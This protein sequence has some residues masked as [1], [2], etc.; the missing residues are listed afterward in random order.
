MIVPRVLQITTLLLLVSIV[1]ACSDGTLIR[2]GVE[3][4][5]DATGTTGPD[6][7]VQT[8]DAAEGGDSG[9][10]LEPTDTGVHDSPPLPELPDDLAG[11][12]IVHEFALP[13]GAKRGVSNWR[14]W[15]RDSLGVAPVFTVPLMNCETLVCYTAEDGGAQL[16]RLDASD[17]LVETTELGSDLECRGLAAATD[18]RF[19]ALLWDDAQDKIYVSRYAVDGTLSGSTELT[20]QSN[21]PDDFQIGDSRLEFGDG[22]YGAYY[23]VHSNDGHE[24]DTLKW[25]DAQTGDE[26]TEWA[27]GCS[28]SMSNVLRY[29]GALNKFMPACVT[30]CYPGTSGNF[31][32]GSMGGIYVNH[33][34]GHVVDVDAG[35]NGSV[36][37]ELGSAAITPTGWTM[38]FN[39]HQAAATPGQSSYDRSTMN[40]DVGWA[41]IAADYSSSDVVW[42]TDTPEVDESDASI[43]RWQPDQDEQYIVGWLQGQTYFL[44]RVNSA[45]ALLE[46]PVDISA[47][48]QWGRRDDPF[49]QH[50]N[51]DVVW[52]WFDTRGSTTLRFAR[53]RAG[54]DHACTTF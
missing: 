4:E 23:H 22:K 31:S 16:V 5:P 53:L 32:T 48:A 21:K 37:G 19:A 50:V 10:S 54:V 7:T 13:K 20:N 6:V 43:A 17:M 28:H 40:Q 26:S 27:W 11:R 3:S 35:C 39:A 46:G 30:D 49:R 25:V 41:T 9:G 51:R 44:S 29:N 33:R 18:G 1:T 14:I 12:L 24:G 42:L 36:A 45:G 34:S 52:S 8:N 47:K 38:V 15:G 2:R